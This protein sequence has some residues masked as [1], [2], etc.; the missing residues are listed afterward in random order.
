MVDVLFFADLQESVG[1]EKLSFE[2][3]GIS[4]KELKDKWLESYELE[5]INDAMVA[6]NEEY[7]DENSILNKGDVVAFIPPVSGG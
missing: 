7:A 1:K 6:I 4:V 5:N 2:V 3:D